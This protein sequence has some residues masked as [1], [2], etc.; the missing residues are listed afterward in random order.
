MVAATALA[1]PRGPRDINLL[2]TAR[3]TLRC[4]T[5]VRIRRTGFFR[6]LIAAC[7]L[8]IFGITFQNPS[9]AA[10]QSASAAHPLAEPITIAADWCSRWQQGNYEVWHLKGNCYINQGLTYARAPEAV[11]WIE[12][13]A[14]N[15]PHRIIAYM[16]ASDREQV[17]VDDSQLELPVDGQQDTRKS[18]PAWFKR[19]ATTGELRMRL[20]D[21][22]I[23]A[24]KPAERRRPGRRG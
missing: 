3:T 17:V 24:P 14:P 16:E 7:C 8:A 23:A 13:F 1:R 4:P 20:P 18:Q 5:T 12:N 19:L 22:V 15:E 9:H 21:P 6:A 2:T 11:L 10:E